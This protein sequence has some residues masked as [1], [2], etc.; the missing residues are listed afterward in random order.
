MSATV[1]TAQ[2]SEILGTLRDDFIIPGLLV[3]Q[4]SRMFL[5]L[6]GSFCTWI[7]A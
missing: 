5:S 7:K 2:W 4:R 1:S 6:V 3:R